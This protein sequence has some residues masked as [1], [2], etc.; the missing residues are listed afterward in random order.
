MSDKIRRYTAAKYREFKMLDNLNNQSLDG[1][2]L[3]RNMHAKPNSAPHESVRWHRIQ[4]L[5]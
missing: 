4:E 5:V 1:E 3:C 2:Q